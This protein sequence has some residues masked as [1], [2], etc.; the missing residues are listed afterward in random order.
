MQGKRAT[1]DWGEAVLRGEESEG[2]ERRGWTVDRQGP[3]FE[4]EPNQGRPLA[5][6]AQPAGHVPHYIL[7]NQVLTSQLVLN[8]L[9]TGDSTPDRPLLGLI[10]RCLSLDAAWRL[11]LVIVLLAV[12]SSSCQEVRK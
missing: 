7:P 11:L 1:S 9:R 10:I 8:S 5:A 4:V 12:H 2:D 6:H 3:I